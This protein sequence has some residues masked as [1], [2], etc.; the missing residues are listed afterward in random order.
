MS[1][2]MKKTHQPK[3]RVLE[4]EELYQGIP[5]EYHHLPFLLCPNYLALTSNHHHHGNNHNHHQDFG[6]RG[7]AGGDSPWGHHFSHANASGGDFQSRASEYSISMMSYDA[8]S[9]TGDNLASGKAGSGRRRRPGIPHS[10]I[11]TVC[12]N[13]VYFFRTRCLIHRKSKGLRCCSWRYPSTLK[14]VELKWDEKG[15]RRNGDRGYSHHGMASTRPKSPTTPRTPLSNVELSFVMSTTYS[16][17]STH[18]HPV[19]L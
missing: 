2:H 7:V 8:M 10:K 14:H 3:P 15:L 17:F 1:D 12:S 18:H 11:C 5:D 4:L 16:P 6:L 13:H 9:G 19:P